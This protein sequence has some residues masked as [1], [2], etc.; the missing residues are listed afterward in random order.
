MCKSS[1]K[2]LYL[3]ICLFL[4]PDPLPKKCVYLGQLLCIGQI[5]HS[6]SQE[7]IEQSVCSQQG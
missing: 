1:F 3:F 4:T 2:L 5:V 7:H 6:D